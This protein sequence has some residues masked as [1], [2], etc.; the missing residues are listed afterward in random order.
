MVFMGTPCNTFSRLRSH[1]GG[2]P[3]LRS[4]ARPQGLHRDELTNK[5]FDT[6]TSGNYFAARSAETATLCCDLNMA[7]AIE[8]PQPWE[9]TASLWDLKQ[10]IQL[11]K[12]SG[13]K[14][15]DFDQCIM[16]SVSTKPTRI[17][18][19]RLDLSKIK[20]K[21]T[22]KQSGGRYGTSRTDPGTSASLT[23]RCP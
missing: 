11:S 6:L 10:F 7:W 22:T 13:V 5:D 15:Q 2:P 17:M 1:P 19:Y 23:S 14:T 20:G 4:K 21:C 9:D 16:G 12:V 18:H 3:P 8:N